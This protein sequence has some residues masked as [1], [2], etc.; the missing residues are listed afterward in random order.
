[1]EHAQ[2]IGPASSNAAPQL[3][4]LAASAVQA[5]FPSP[6][7]D[8]AAKRI[9][10]NEELIVHPQAT[11]YMRVAGSSMVGHRIDDGDLLV[12]DRAIRPRHGHIVVAVLDGE[13]TVKQLYSRGGR[14]KLKAGNPTYPDIVPKDAQ[15][16]V[17]WGVV[18]HCIKSM[19][20]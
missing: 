14:I 20:R 18:S 7:E 12:V 16:L 13:F 15:E 4:P 5:G 2:L 1:M 11:F 6:A 3:L 10:L 8:F 17:I 9:D 19:Y